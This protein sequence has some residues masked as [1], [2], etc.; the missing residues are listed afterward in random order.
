MAKLSAREQ[1]IA[2]GL[3]TLH[4]KGFNGSGVQDI[5]DAAGVP[6]GSFYNYFESK[7]AFAVAVLDRYF[8]GGAER[9]AV[10]SDERIPPLERLGR[11]VDGVAA[12][13]TEHQFQ[14]CMVGNMGTEMSEQSRLVR[15][16]LSSIFAA[17]TRAVENCLREAQQ[18]GDLRADL[19]VG[20]VA[21]FFLNAWQ[22]AV[23]RTKVDK[24]PAAFDQ[25]KAVVF[26]QLFV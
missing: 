3:E 2:A 15:D 16:R 10:L 23:L 20:A 4:R 6:K 11:Y 22:G 18:T 13:L 21:A 19:D 5:T 7:E 17:W 9:M 25:F 1:L 26:K 12:H 14:G 8:Q 24:D